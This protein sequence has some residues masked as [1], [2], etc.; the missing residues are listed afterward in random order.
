MEFTI[1]NNN[2]L[3]G[4]HHYLIKNSNFGHRTSPPLETYT[5]HIKT[6]NSRSE[7]NKTIVK[8]D[9]TGTLASLLTRASQLFERKKIVI[10]LA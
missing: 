3:T 4:C 10:K 2:N 1:S 7:E 8:T 5:L 6:S 9:Y